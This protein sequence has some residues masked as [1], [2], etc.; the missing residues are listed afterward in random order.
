MD[1]KLEFIDNI[2]ENKFMELYKNNFNI[3]NLEL[4]IVGFPSIIYIKSRE[5]Y[6]N[7]KPGEID[8]ITIQDNQRLFKNITLND[9]EKILKEYNE[10]KINTIKE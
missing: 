10:R 3:L 8:L 7:V 9:V 2:E 4:Y 5:W 1:C 6:N